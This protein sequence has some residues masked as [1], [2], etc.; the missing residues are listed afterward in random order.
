MRTKPGS[1]LFAL[2]SLCLSFFS[3]DYCY[4]QHFEISDQGYQPNSNLLESD[5]ENVSNDGVTNLTRLLLKFHN[6]TLKMNSVDLMKNSYGNIVYVNVNATG[7]NNGNSWQD[8]FTKLQDGLDKARSINAQVWVA[9]GVYQENLVMRDNV[10]IWGGFSGNETTLNQRNHSR[11]KTTIDGRNHT[12]AILCYGSNTIDGFTIKNGYRPEGTGEVLQSRGGGIL[13]YRASGVVRNNFITNNSAGWGGGIYV[14]GNVNNPGYV[15]IEYNI[16]TGNTGTCCAG[17]VEIDHSHATVKYNT[18]VDNVGHGLEIPTHPPITLGDFHSNIADGNEFNH[19]PRF[20]QRPKGYELWAYA[21]ACTDYSFIGE[22]WDYDS[23]WGSPFS[24]PTNIYGDYE[25][26]DPL[27]VNRNGQDFRLQSNSPCIR[28]G[29]PDGSGR[30]TDMGAIRYT[31]NNTETVSIPEQP[32][33][34][35][36]GVVGASLNFST[37]SAVSSLGHAV[38]YRFDWGDGNQ[39]SWGGNSSSHSYSNTGTYQIRARARCQ[40]HTSIESN[41]SNSLN[42]T[43]SPDQYVVSGKVSYYSNNQP[44]QDVTLTVTGDISKTSVTNSNG[45]YSFNLEA[46]NSVT[47]TSA[48]SKADDVGPYDITTYDASL[49]A[50]HVLD[51][52]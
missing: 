18:I 14:D 35:T 33:G 24:H 44:V 22:I 16:I 34:P 3:F 52:E 40:Q 48:K 17:G 41:W 38:E 2:I 19:H 47:V 42:V 27:F 26:K 8:A 9:K 50:R 46:G 36:Q 43:I 37:G 12:R 5:I 23:R 20:S 13:F 4:S 28:A 39:S 1:C 45:N 6:D 11:N 32:S 49:T 15:L 21:R 51:L 10:G 31:S 30:A 25:N 7:A 29:K